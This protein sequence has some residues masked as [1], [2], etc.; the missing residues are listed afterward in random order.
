MICVRM[1]SARANSFAEARKRSERGKT[2]EVIDVEPLAS[3]DPEEK[4][5]ASL[6]K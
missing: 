5:E 6:L 4:S 1:A 2:M 3:I